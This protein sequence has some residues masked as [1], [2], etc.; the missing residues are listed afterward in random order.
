M[1]KVCRLFLSNETIY[2]L[3]ENLLLFDG[4]IF[5]FLLAAFAEL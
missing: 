3:S 4:K 5:V 2:N 1:I